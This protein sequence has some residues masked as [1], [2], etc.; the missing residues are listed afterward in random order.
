MLINLLKRGKGIVG[1]ATKEIPY[2]KWATEEKVLFKS[3]PTPKAK[4][5]IGK[6]LPGFFGRGFYYS[7]DPRYTKTYGSFTKMFRDTRKNPLEWDS[8]TA[9]KI[10][11]KIGFPKDP[12]AEGL[13]YEKEGFALSEKLSDEVKALGYDGINFRYKGKIIEAVSFG[14]L[15]EIPYQKM[16]EGK[17]KSMPSISPFLSKKVRYEGLQ[18]DHLE[19]PRWHMFT[20][21]KSG[22]SFMVP[23]EEDINVGLVKG[24]QRLEE[25]YKL[26]LTREK[27]KGAKGEF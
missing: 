7:Q 21:K 8:Q 6:Q 9:E 11:Q 3:F 4:T 20:D 25:K 24:L 26:G 15:K 10:R 27:F 12:Y 1:K 23:L 5:S 18:R 16:L 13:S 19:R 22:S 17:P 2:Q 14:K